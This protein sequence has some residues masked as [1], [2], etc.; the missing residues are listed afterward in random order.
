MENLLMKQNLR[1]ILQVI[2]LIA[3]SSTKEAAHS[4]I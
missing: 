3:T 1:S 2:L 4:L